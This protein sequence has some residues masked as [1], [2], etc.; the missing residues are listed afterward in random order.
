MLRVAGGGG[1]VGCFSTST[2]ELLSEVHIGCGLVT[3][4]SSAVFGGPELR[5][6]YVTTAAPDKAFDFSAEPLAGSLFVVR[7]MPRRGREARLFA[8]AL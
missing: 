6:L 2:G 1:R 4:V 5:D 3:R 8:G 7:H